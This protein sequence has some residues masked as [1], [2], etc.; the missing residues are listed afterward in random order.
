MH[1]PNH[2]V[3]ILK[4]ANSFREFPFQSYRID[5]VSADQNG[6]DFVIRMAEKNYA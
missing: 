6:R 3:A 2:S 4:R 1:L 5:F